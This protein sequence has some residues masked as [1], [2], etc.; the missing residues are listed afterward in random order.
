[1]T[2]HRSSDLQVP[3]HSVAVRVP[4]SSGNLGSGFDCCGLALKLYL[5]VKAEVAPRAKQRCRIRMRGEGSGKLKTLSACENL[6]YRAMR[7]TAEQEGLNLP[8]MRLAVHNQ[9][10]LASGLGSSGA[11][12]IAGIGLCCEICRHK[13]PIKTILR[14][15]TEIEGHADNVAAALLGG[16]VINC[17][18]DDGTVLAAKKFWASGIKVI[19]VTPDFVVETKHARTI[20]PAT[21]NRRDA[22]YNMQRVALLSTALENHDY[23]LL[24]EAMQDRLHQAQRAKLVPGLT[25]ALATPPSPG[26]LGIALSGSGPSVLA[27]A[28]NHFDEIGQQITD[29]FHKHDLKTTVRMLE[30]DDLGLQ[31]FSGMRQVQ[32]SAVSAR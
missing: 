23:D 32:Q 2:D 30:V 25:E 19:V 6:I 3:A 15:A 14:Y 20:L 18:K 7:F 17:I 8:P 11:A 12:I 29:C 24:W 27:L 5:D 10:P 28:S 21:I 31:T 9:I 1:M 26:L 13:V 16:F 22:V 4:A